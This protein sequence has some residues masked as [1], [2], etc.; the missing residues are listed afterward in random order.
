[1]RKI[2]KTYGEKSLDLLEGENIWGE[3]STKL[4][5]ES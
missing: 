2:L 4:K 5:E 3:P 1:M